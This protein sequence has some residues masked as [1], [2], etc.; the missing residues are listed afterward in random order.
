[1]SKD[2]RTGWNAAWLQSRREPRKY[3]PVGAVAPSVAV[4]ISAHRDEV[5]AHGFHQCEKCDAPQEPQ[6]LVGSINF[7]EAIRRAGK[8]AYLEGVAR[9]AAERGE[10]VQFHRPE[11]PK[12]QFTPGQVL[13]SVGAYAAMLDGWILSLNG[14]QY[15]VFREQVQVRGSHDGAKWLES[16]SW[17]DG[18]LIDAVF[19][20]LEQAEP[21]P[22]RQIQSRRDGSLPHPFFAGQRVTGEHALRAMRAGYVLQY[23]CARYRWHD[24][25]VEYT[26]VDSD[27]WG[28]SAMWD[29]SR[30]DCVFTVLAKENEL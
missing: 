19:I 16:D 4:A 14:L 29:G 26:T 21:E 18:E 3:K 10:L 25:E 20:V 17:L 2:A 11:L 27:R 24:G 9:Q 6:F 15:R 5:C 1:M 13:G 7:Y 28:R 22:E 30:R 8:T 23:G 12:F